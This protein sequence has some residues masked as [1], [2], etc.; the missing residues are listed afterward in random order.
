MK[1]FTPYSGKDNPWLMIAASGLVLLFLTLL[2]L[3]VTG[4][5]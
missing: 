3:A 2:A 5:I 1:D 4:K